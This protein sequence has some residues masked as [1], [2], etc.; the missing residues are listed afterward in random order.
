MEDIKFRLFN[1]YDKKMYI[2]EPRWGNFGQGGGW[3]GGVL[4]EDYNKEG[5]TFAPSNQM[6]LEPENCEWLQ[7]T[8]LLDKNDKEIYE[9]DILRLDE[10]YNLW[11]VEWHEAGFYIRNAPHSFDYYALETQLAIT[12]EVCGNIYEN[13][14]LVLNAHQ[15]E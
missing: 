14:E 4:E 8:G 13:A 9:G 1:K 12:R 15:R 7:F 2:F 5:R 6:Q 10:F 11:L 3:V